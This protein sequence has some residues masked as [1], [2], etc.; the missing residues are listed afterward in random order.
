M[1]VNY[2]PEYSHQWNS[3]TYYTQL[4]LDPLGKE[5][6]DEMLTAM[7]GDAVDIRPLK[8]LIIERTQGNPFFMEETVQ[9][10]LD[11]GALVRDGAAAR[12]TKPLGELKIPPTVQAI[13]AARIDRLAANEKD[14][15]QTLAVIGKEFPLSLVRTVLGTDLT[16]V[17]FPHGKG[18]A[19]SNAGSRTEELDRMLSELQLAEFVYEQPA[20][21]DIEYTFKHALT[22]EVAY[23]SI[24]SE[25]RKQLHE[26]IGAAIETLFSDSLDDHIAELA[27]HYARSGNIRRAATYQTLAG[28]QAR[29]RGAI[30]EAIACFT[31][32]LNLVRG[33]PESATRGREELALQLMLADS[34]RALKS[35][36][37]EVEQA[38][39]L[40]RD[41]AIQLGD[42]ESA[43]LADA[44]LRWVRRFRHEFAAARELGERM[45]ATARRLRDPSKTVAAH[46]A[47]GDTLFLMGD[48][49]AA[50]DNFAR[51]LEIGDAKFEVGAEVDI[52][53]VSVACA[54][55]SFA[56]W[57]L[58][59]PEQ[60]AKLYANRLEEATQK[61]GSDARGV[62]A[63][64]T[65]VARLMGNPKTAR[66]SC[67][68]SIAI[69]SQ[70]GQRFFEAVGIVVRG[71]AIAKLGDPVTGIDEIERGM[72]MMREGGALVRS[73]DRAGLAE[74]YA[75]AGK[76]RD[77][78]EQISI[79][80]A[81]IERTGERCFE[82]EL[83]RLNGEI[84]SLLSE[85]DLSAIERS[86]RTAIE[87]AR[88][89]GAKSFE[90]RATVSLAR[91]LDKQGNRDEARAVLSD[92]YNWF[93]EGFDTADLKD[94]KAL[95]DELSA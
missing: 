14:L 54:F 59:F 28:T 64:F 40:A 69:A 91:L 33:L 42:E 15:L 36:H 75:I 26:R 6:A 61:I 22:Q 85:N 66:V 63:A 4:R 79:A 60:S 88:N 89:Q 32:A 21:G 78:L 82:S 51:V 38:Y 34:L 37:S 12:L 71:W 57:L 62:L 56:I 48:P 10:L 50:R 92:I 84:L 43:F 1:L 86:Y 76:P 81:E 55:L 77:G 93:T 19:L 80:L 11:E 53:M 41:H 25:R 94:A 18:D 74:A 70:L 47:L 65:T 7:V 16:P 73:F 90:L 23:N 39:L 17:P 44:G 2:R 27:H 5:N 8:S 30:P 67:D 58:G 13:L 52:M 3:K 45:L 68:E 20:V 87:V 9:V 31:A 24:L 46:V 49:A 72:A 95:L 83:H 35:G 29:K